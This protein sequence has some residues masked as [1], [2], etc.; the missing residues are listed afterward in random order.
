MIYL[1]NDTFRNPKRKR[2][3]FFFDTLFLKCIYIMSTKGIMPP[4][5]Q[6]KDNSS[7][8]SQM[9]TTLRNAWNTRYRAQLNGRTLGIT[10]FRAVNNAGDLLGRQGY[11]CG[12]INATNSR[13]GLRGLK[14]GGVRNNCDGTGVPA[15][16]C[17]GKYV[18]D[19]S[20]YTTYLRQKAASKNYND[21]SFSGN[22]SNAS[23]SAFR[24]IRT[25]Y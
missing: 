12:A 19:S 1:L 14:L 16:A 5:T 7:E 2:I 23:Q 17:N 4:P 20:N 6:T 21:F 11:S 10:P 3:E 18:Y 22:D 25:G 13:P 8:F 9:R 15:G 24:R